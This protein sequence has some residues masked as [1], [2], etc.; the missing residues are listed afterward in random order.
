M[1]GDAIETFKIING[2]VNYGHNM[3]GTT[4]TY[5]T[6]NVNVTSHHPLRSA[7]DVLNNRVIKYWNQLPLR[8]RNS[9]SI[10]AVKAGLDLFKLSKPDSPNGFWKLSEEIFNRISDKSEHVN[11]L[12]ANRDFFLWMVLIFIFYREKVK[13]DSA[14]LAGGNKTTSTF[15]PCG[16][17]RMKELHVKNWAL[18]S[19]DRVPHS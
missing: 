1:R 13:Y 7:H 9:T 16:F 19:R 4:T 6:R 3:F 14:P 5:Q 18:E 11:Y 17:P 15:A 8:V 12:L 10:N 2:F